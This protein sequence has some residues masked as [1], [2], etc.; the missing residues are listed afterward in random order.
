MKRKTTERPAHEKKCN[1]DDCLMEKVLTTLMRDSGFRSKSGLE[2][3]TYAGFIFN[4]SKMKRD[5]CKP[6]AGMWK[7]PETKAKAK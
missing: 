4:L 5:R 2:K 6:V 3:V 1:C 7:I